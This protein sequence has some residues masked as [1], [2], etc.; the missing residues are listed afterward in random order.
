MIL[1]IKINSNF[2]F[3]INKAYSV[4]SDDKQ[5]KDYDKWMGSGLNVSYEQWKELST[6]THTSLHWGTAKSQLALEGFFCFLYMMI[7]FLCFS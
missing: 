4:L 3:R 5:R 2:F 7:P 1:I 6:A